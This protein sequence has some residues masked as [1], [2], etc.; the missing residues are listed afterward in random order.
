MSVHPTYFDDVP[1]VTFF[2]DNFANCKAIWQLDISSFW[3]TVTKFC[4][5]KTPVCGN[6]TSADN[7]RFFKNVGDQIVR[8]RRKE[9]V[10]AFVLGVADIRLV[11]AVVRRGEVS[12][13]DVCPGGRC[14]TIRNHSVW[15]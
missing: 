2:N 1:V 4:K 11:G 13:W 5:L 8:S 14:P 9:N 3:S 6:G 15:K 10:R 7:R 12:W